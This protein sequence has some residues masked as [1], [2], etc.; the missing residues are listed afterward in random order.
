MAQGKEERLGLMANL[1]MEQKARRDSRESPSRDRSAMAEFQEKTLDL[2][3]YLEKKAERFGLEDKGLKKRMIEER[4]LG[5]RQK[6]VGTNFFIN[7]T[8]PL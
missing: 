1:R 5:I 8:Q 3:M 6:V 4:G 7:S 2:S